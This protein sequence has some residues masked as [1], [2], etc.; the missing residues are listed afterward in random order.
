MYIPR[1]LETCVGAA[2]QQFPILLITGARQVGK[3]SLLR[4]IF[5]DYGYVTLDIP[6]VAEQAET[7]PELFLEEHSDPVIISTRSSSPSTSITRTWPVSKPFGECTEAKRSK[8]PPS[9]AEPG[10]GI[11]RH[12]TPKQSTFSKT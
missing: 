9:C 5:P 6:S 2:S 3:T 7:N 1:T 4:K 10:S 11:A 12:R 8:R